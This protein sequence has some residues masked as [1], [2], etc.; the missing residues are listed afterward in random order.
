M[1]TLFYARSGS[2]NNWGFTPTAW[3]AFRPFF[4]YVAYL[5]QMPTSK[6]STHKY[7]E[8][9]FEAIKLFCQKLKEYIQIWYCL[10]FLT[11]QL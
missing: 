1:K 11:S 4:L 5:R 3:F 7:K 2:K 6:Q 9:N 10:G 8:L